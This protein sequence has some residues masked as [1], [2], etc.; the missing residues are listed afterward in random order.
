LKQVA[1]NQP[2]PKALARLRASLS[3]RLELL[4]DGVA[5]AFALSGATVAAVLGKLLIGVVLAGLAIGFVLRLKSRKAKLASPAN[6]ATAP[7]TGLARLGA[8]AASV[9]EVALLVEAANLPVRFNQEGF[10]MGHW[11]LV[12]LALAAAYLLQLPLFSRLLAKQRP[13]GAA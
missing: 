10:H 12:L 6:E 5:V 13:P 2:R 4:L 11:Y 9:A 8:G 7:V 3:E 1:T